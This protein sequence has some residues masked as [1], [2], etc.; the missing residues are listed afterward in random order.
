MTLDDP[1]VR[2]PR[3]LW[4]LRVL[5]A[6][7]SRVTWR[8]R[9][10]E[11]DETLAE[12]PV[13]NP[14]GGSVAAL[15]LVE[16]GV[17]LGT[18]GKP[19]LAAQ[20]LTR[21]VKNDPG[22]PAA[23]YNLAL[24]LDQMGEHAEA[25]QSYRRAAEIAPDSVDVRVNLGAALLASGD[26]TAAL[27]EFESAVELDP[28]DAAAWFGLGCAHLANASYKEAVEAFRNAIKADPD[29]P[30]T[31]FNLAIALSRAGCPDLAEIE[32]RAFV[33]MAG[34]RF[35]AHRAHAE[36]VLATQAEKEGGVEDES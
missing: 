18:L 10:H 17:R 28:R 23:H 27:A 6:V 36:Q 25:I 22:D 29:D 12:T 14:E 19:E 21:A 13:S 20:R 9:K 30:E 31:R 33:D 11:S 15:D 8:F 24:A 35:P 3:V 2:R 26:R 34:D 4:L 7:F 32:L 16:W 5:P 1:M